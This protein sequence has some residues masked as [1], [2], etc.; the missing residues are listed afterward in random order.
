MTQRK[1]SVKQK[2]T[3]LEYRL[4]VAKGEVKGDGL[5]L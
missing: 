2:H 5:G 4:V 3:H 1:L